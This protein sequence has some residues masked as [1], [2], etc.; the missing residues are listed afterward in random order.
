MLKE[1]TSNWDSD[2]EEGDAAAVASNP[3]KQITALPVSAVPSSQSMDEEGFKVPGAKKR[4]R[5]TMER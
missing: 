5:A 2:D 4:D 3:V 1:R